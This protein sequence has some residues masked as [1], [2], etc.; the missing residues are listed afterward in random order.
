MK[1]LIILMIAIL[2]VCSL[3]AESNLEPVRTHIVYGYIQ[4]LDY[5][6]VPPTVVGVEGVRVLVT[7]SGDGKPDLGVVDWT[8]E[9]G[10]YYVDGRD[11]GIPDGYTKVSISNE[12]YFHKTVSWNY[13]PVRIDAFIDRIM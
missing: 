4:E 7:F 8:D 3:I 11:Y 2:A 12:Y 10:Y 1:K 6:T 13:L 5:S 9:N